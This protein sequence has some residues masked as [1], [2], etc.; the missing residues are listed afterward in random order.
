MLQKCG[1]KKIRADH[2]KMR[3]RSDGVADCQNPKFRIEACQQ[4]THVQLVHARAS[5]RADGTNKGSVFCLATYYRWLASTHCFHHANKKEQKMINLIDELKELGIKNS[6]IWAQVIDGE[7]V[8]W[9]HKPDN[10]RRQMCNV[11]VDS[12]GNIY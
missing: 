7:I 10:I 6:G 5:C 1:H 12:L 9:Y 3:L 4:N 8:A 11:Y 2:L